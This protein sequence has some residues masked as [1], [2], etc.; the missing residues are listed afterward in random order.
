M[1]DKCLLKL[2]K[3]HPDINKDTLKQITDNMDELHAAENYGARAQEWRSYFLYEK[4]R[5]LELKTRNIVAKQKLDKFIDKAEFEGRP[6]DAF[7]AKVFGVDYLT[8]GGNFNFNQVRKNIMEKHLLQLDEGLGKHRH[9]IAS[10]K[11]DRQI[12]QAIYDLNNGN[13][14]GDL[15]EVVVTAARSI[16]A[17]NRALV[18]ELRDLGVLISIRDDYIARQTHDAARI[19]E[20][21][22]DTWKQDIEPK[23]DAPKTFGPKNTPAGREGILRQIYDDILADEYEEGVGAF[24]GKRSLHFLDGNNWSDYNSLYGRGNLLDTVVASVASGSKAGASTAIFGPDG[25]ALWKHMEKKVVEKLKKAGD[26]KAAAEFMNESNT[27]QKGIRDQWLKEMYGYERHDHKAWW[28]KARAELSTWAA[29][30]KLGK[31]AISTMTDLAA[32]S[33]NLRAST[34]GHLMSAEWDTITSFFKTLS[35]DNR[36]QWAK[37]LSMYTGSMLNETFDRFGGFSGDGTIHTKAG[38]YRTFTNGMMSLTMLQRQS[39]TMKMANARLFAIDMGMNAGKAF[40]QLPARQ[41]AG[42]QRFGITA[43]EW[44]LLRQNTVEIEGMQVIVGESATKI[45]D[46][47]LSAARKKELELKVQSYLRDMSEVG[48][49]EAT[50][51]ERRMIT[52]GTSP[53]SKEG[54]LLRLAGQFKSFP[55]AIPRVMRRIALSNPEIMAKDITG[56]KSIKEILAAAKD[57]EE[58]LRLYRQSGD[59]HMVAALMTEATA[60]AGVAL[61]LKD[62]AAGRTPDPTTPD[63]FMDAIASGAA[64]LSLSYTMDALRGEYNRYGRTIFKDLAGPTL[65]QVPDLMRI[66]AGTA[67]LDPKTAPKALRFL[68]NNTPGINM[69]LVR[70][71][72]HKN[73]LDDMYSHYNP[74]YMKRMRMKRERE[75]T[76]SLFGR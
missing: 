13:K 47:A 24:G 7:L 68:E 15:P 69:P 28:S 19:R 43:E 57:P 46:G 58:L 48:S 72:L 14:L 75:R 27:G 11:F 59:L 61:I 66:M 51:R 29:I 40:D 34:G 71:V 44:D 23:L 39:T 38:L 4:E 64:P 76:N 30:T 5:Q 70:P 67:R 54:A 20:K 18:T 33:M 45:S 60:L 35:G 74:R 21:G 26:N 52:R 8:K 65:G 1:S 9:E 63:F 22:F 16:R 6:Q 37:A 56:A 49:P 32:S 53:D 17:V 10:G 55:L 12:A 62:F 42:M 73:F 36:K 3:L 2:S 41:R 31:A 25:K 50:G